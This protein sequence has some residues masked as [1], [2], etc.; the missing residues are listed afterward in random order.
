[1][2]YSFS[3]SKNRIDQKISLYLTFNCRFGVSSNMHISSTI[4]KDLIKVKFTTPNWR[5]LLGILVNNLV[6]FI[7]LF[8]FF[9]WGYTLY[10]LWH[11]LLTPTLTHFFQSSTLICSTFTL[12]SFFF[13]QLLF[14]CVSAFAFIAVV[15]RESLSL[16]FI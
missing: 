6:D 2:F 8:L 9:F 15:V 10:T 3:D 7:L 14:R 11:Q 5:F 1:M 13:S 16:N 4:Y 12:H